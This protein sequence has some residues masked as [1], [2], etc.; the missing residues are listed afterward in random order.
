MV[1][2]GVQLA[3]EEEVRNLDISMA[4]LIWL[5]AGIYGGRDGNTPTVRQSNGHQGW[6]C[7]SQILRG[8]IKW[9]LKRGR[10]LEKDG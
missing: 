7:R 10:K 1:Q 8:I 5:G 3:F 4:E 9:L 6:L 2:Y